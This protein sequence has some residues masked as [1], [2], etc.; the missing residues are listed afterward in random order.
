MGHTDTA[1]RN[2]IIL[3]LEPAAQAH[4]LG[5]ALTRPLHVGETIYEE[6]APV[7]HAIFPHAG[8]VSLMTEMK[9]GRRIETV[10]I[11]S[12]GFLGF[13]L[14]LGSQAAIRRSVVKV[15]GRAS[16]VAVREL[17]EA[18]AE[19]PAIRE[20]LVHSARG[21]M[22]QAIQA[23]AC[24]ALHSAEARVVRWLLSTHDRIEGDRF[25]VTQQTMADVL[26]L[27]RATVN[28]AFSALESQGLIEL[29]RGVVLIANRQRLEQRACECYG[30]IAC[31]FGFKRTADA[32]RPAPDASK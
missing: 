20:A 29:S 15:R 2:R 10:S 5:R 6:G 4:V 27:R 11:G 28:E 25:E 3:G 1:T 30:K 23:A 12:E 9:D 18:M 7:T 32:E 24:N 19:F 31:S 21:L 17:N 14:V 16:W 13:S 26:G 8:V 22:L